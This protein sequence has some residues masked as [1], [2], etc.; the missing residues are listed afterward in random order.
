MYRT[1]IDREPNKRDWIQSEYKLQ[2]NMIQ[3]I[4]NNVVSE[5]SL[6]MLCFYAC[7]H[8]KKIVHC[9]LSVV[10]LRRKLGAKNLCVLIV[11]V[12]PR[13]QLQNGHHQDPKTKFVCIV[14]HRKLQYNMWG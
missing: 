2:Y 1:Q 3:Y 6:S 9:L 10:S 12:E 5:L 8:A 7:I 11:G 4:A 13:H 14:H